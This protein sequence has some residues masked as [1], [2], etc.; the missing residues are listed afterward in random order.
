MNMRE[1][2]L[3]LW[4]IRDNCPSIFYPTYCNLSHKIE[5][6][7]KDKKSKLQIREDP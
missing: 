4:P 5:S 7:G 2:S 1:I 6:K 3:P